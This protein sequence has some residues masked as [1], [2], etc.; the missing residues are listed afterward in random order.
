MAAIEDY[1]T[2]N[3]PASITY[4]EEGHADDP[5]LISGATIR[6]DEFAFAAEDAL[7]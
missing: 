5:D 7:K 1:A 3:G 6:V 4:D 2:K